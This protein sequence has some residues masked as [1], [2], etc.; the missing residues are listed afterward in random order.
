MYKPGDYVVG[1]PD[2]YISDNKKYKFGGGKIQYCE[3]KWSMIA[4]R[5]RTKGYNISWPLVDVATGE[6]DAKGVKI[7]PSYIGYEKLQGMIVEVDEMGEERPHWD[8][9]VRVLTG[10]KILWFWP[11]N[12]R[13]VRY[14]GAKS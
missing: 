13:L 1:Y 7:Y 12:V 14:A 6:L 3:N 10:E 5:Q 4:Q 11:R 8:G 2:F 9:I